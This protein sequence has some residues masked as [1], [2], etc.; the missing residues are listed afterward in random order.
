MLFVCVFPGQVQAP[1]SRHLAQLEG[2]GSGRRT[3]F[4]Q[5]PRLQ[6]G[7]VQ[8]GPVRRQRWIG[9]DRIHTSRMFREILLLSLP[10]H[11]DIPKILT[12]FSFLSFMDQQDQDFHPAPKN[13]V[14]DRRRLSS[15]QTQARWAA[16]EDAVKHLIES[17]REYNSMCLLQLPE[18]KPSTRATGWKR[19]MPNRK[20]PVCELNNRR[21]LNIFQ[22]FNLSS[23]CLNSHQDWELLE[24][25]AG[26]EGAREEGVGRQSHQE[27]SSTFLNKFRNLPRN[28]MPIWS[29]C[30]GLSG[31]K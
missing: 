1:L 10:T 5:T 28:Q 7:W 27:V 29:I 22:I 14:R 31:A 3:A 30:I 16:N 11:D 20:R 17:Y 21:R 8:D 18:S 25:F 4:D 26:Q 9:C 2:L 15:L 23:S 13:S 24:R 6:T 12:E 19:N